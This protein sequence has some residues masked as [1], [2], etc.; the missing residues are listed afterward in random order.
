[1]I[2]RKKF[3]L[4][5]HD[6][7]RALSD[8]DAKRRSEQLRHAAWG[9]RHFVE[10]LKVN[11]HQIGSLL[12]TLRVLRNSGGPGSLAAEE[13][14]MGSLESIAIQ[15]SLVIEDEASSRDPNDDRERALEVLRRLD[16]FAQDCLH[17]RRA[18]DSFGG[19]RRSM[20]F[21]ILT[22]TARHLPRP[23]MVEHAMATIQGSAGG[24]VPGA[25]ELLRSHFER[26]DAAPDS[27]LTEALLKLA[28]VTHSRFVAFRAL[29]L[30]VVTGVI[31]EGEA[32]DR[33]SDWKFKRGR[34]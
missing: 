2:R 27:A 21:G 32:C 14:I 16:A 4:F 15:A 34:L 23:D 3:E 11:P 29:D 19:R 31:S 24:D 28:E 33:L 5:L 18:R 10:Q 1:M 9:V 26:L 8:T 22:A 13:Q 20:A 12:D 7:S 25:M 30:L 17:Y 6:L